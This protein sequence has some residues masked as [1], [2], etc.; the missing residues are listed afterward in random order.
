[1]KSKSR[2]RNL[3]STVFLSFGGLILLVAVVLINGGGKEPQAGRGSVPQDGES[4]SS[5]L[6]IEQALQSSKSGKEITRERIASLSRKLD[7]I[8][9]DPNYREHPSLLFDLMSGATLEEVKM[10]LS[11]AE[12]SASYSI[13]FKESVAAAGYER[14]YGLDPAGGIRAL[15]ASSLGERRKNTV[16]E[17]LLED[18][19]NKSPEE[20]LQFLQEGGLNGVPA[21]TVYGSLVRGSAQKGDRASVDL[22]LQNIKDPKLHS[23]ALRSA[24]RSLQASHAQEYQEW[25]ETLPP[26]QQGA[27]LGESAWILAEKKEIEGAL[28][29]LQRLQDMDA[30]S[31]TVARR[32]VAVEWARDNP[33][34]AAEWLVSQ[35]IPT[36]E[37]EILFSNVLRVWLADDNN[38]AVEWIESQ[39]NSG[40]FE[41][42]FMNRLARRL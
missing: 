40:A 11:L 6:D 4:D 14:W 20:V 31:L 3:K 19:A 25:V 32:K 42:E 23:F 35:E 18:W 33:S 5:Q 13:G 22:A 26:V 29:T 41:E 21:D 30:E 16:A 37:Q 1:M 24:A 15:D 27:A 7:L 28:G 2:K 39:L 10:L 8:L 36:E 34:S 9:E 38:A 12:G 17:V